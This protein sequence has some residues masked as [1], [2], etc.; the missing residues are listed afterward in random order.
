ML[1]GDHHGRWALLGVCRGFVPC[2]GCHSLCRAVTEAAVGSVEEAFYAPPA[3][4]TVTATIVIVSR[5]QCASCMATWVGPGKACLVVAYSKGTLR[6]MERSWDC[7]RR[8]ATL[9]GN[10]Q[11]MPVALQ[12]ATPTWHASSTTYWLRNQPLLPATDRNQS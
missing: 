4:T 9:T 11:S 7:L 2:R 5:V 12:L 10:N 3:S 1:G 6:L 8:K